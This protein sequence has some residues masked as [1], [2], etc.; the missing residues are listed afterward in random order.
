MS[1]RKLTDF[2]YRLS[3]WMLEHSGP[4]A[5]TFLTQLEL[6]EVTSWRCPCG[7]ASLNFQIQGRPEAPPGVHPIAEF[8]FG[9]GED[10]SGI[11]IYESAGILSGLEVYG[12]GGPA[13]KSLPAPGL[14]RP[15]EASAPDA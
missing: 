4:E 15:F 12:L 1:N 6:T 5:L 2:E 8:L 10:L 7:C 11:F 13:P 9:E 3:R 14:L